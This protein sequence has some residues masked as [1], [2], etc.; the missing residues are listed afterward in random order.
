MAR[1]RIDKIAQLARQLEFSPQNTRA[2][3]LTAA[4]ELLHLLEPAKAYP[5][6]FVVYRITGY[7]PRV[8]GEEL[9]TGLALQHDLGL[10][11][12]RVSDTLGLRTCSEREPVLSIDDV[13][14]R[15][16]VTSK[17]IQ[18][19]R[20]RGLPARRLEF[21]DG[22]QRVGFLLSSVERFFSNQRDQ[23]PRGANFALVTAQEYAEIIRRARRLAVECQ[24]CVDEICRRIG[25]KLN[26]SPLAIL[27]AI[28]RHDRDYPPEA[29][30][31]SAAGPVNREQR[32]RLA[33]AYGQGVPVAGLAQR[34]GLS[35]AAV[36]RTLIEERAWRL[37][38]KRVRFIDDPLYHAANAQRAIDTIAAQDEL[39][40]QTQ[41]Q[42]PRIPRDLPCYLHGLCAAPLLSPGRERGLF[43]KFNFH[44]FQFAFARR[45]LEVQFAR[46]RDLLRL[47]K[48]LAK[49][50]QTRND[51]VAANMRLV[52][53]IARRHLRPGMTLPE[54]ISEGTITLMR[55]V[56]GFDIHK[57]YRFSTYA[58]LALMKGFAR[59][60]PAMLAPHGRR[61]RTCQGLQEVADPHVAGAGEH[62]LVRDEV[63]SLLRLLDENER[64]VVR[65][66]FGL[67]AEG[68]TTT[69][70]PVADGLVLSRRQAR[71][72][73][74]K[75]MNKLRAAGYR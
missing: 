41:R 75:A 63:D 20:R 44:K 74:Q 69:Y 21:P 57:G 32:E 45:K 28:R 46:H 31:P 72:I 48:Y 26:R 43:L 11:I 24:C 61:D 42:E 40:P 29:I 59:S 39:L 70:H 5:F 68:G 35:C 4:E 33:R 6:D 56:D 49:A 51:I 18:R 65:A 34:F 19:W 37:G 62:L 67:G 15:F 10:L 36:A 58:T 66:H 23:V 54:L 1:Y 2:A 25:R 30:V 53:S 73:E 47:E 3:Q 38:R 14:E 64:R 12:E 9:L 22:K 17:T 7:H 52:V 27:H 55:A 71:Q 8:V 13:C 60:V 16:G 50:A